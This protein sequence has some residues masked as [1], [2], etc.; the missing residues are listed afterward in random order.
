MRRELIRLSDCHDESLDYRYTQ[1]HNRCSG[2]YP[3][4]IE[5]AMSSSSQL[6]YSKR[7]YALLSSLVGLIF[8]A[9]LVDHH[10]FSRVVIGVLLIISLIIATQSVQRT[11]RFDVKL[12]LLAVFASLLWVMT[13]WVATFP[14]NTIYFKIAS[15]GAVLVFF[16]IIG[17]NILQDVLSGRVNANRICGSICVLVLIGFCFSMIHMM[18]H[19]CDPQAYK[20]NSSTSAIPITGHESYPLFG[21]FSFCTLT[22]VGYGDV[23]PISRLARCTSCLEALIGQLYLVILISRLVGLH[24]AGSASENELSENQRVARFE[25]SR[26]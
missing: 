11:M 2:T 24:I 7:Y 16:V 3:F 17:S 8:L 14:F 26:R 23:V 6:L 1:L 4:P 18:I 10:I 5:Q 9:P 15:L 12:C 13:F 19:I 21:Y 20:D 22:T 25:T